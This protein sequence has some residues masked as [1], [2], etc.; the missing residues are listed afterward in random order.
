M[1]LDPLIIARCSVKSSLFYIMI[2][3]EDVGLPKRQQIDEP[4]VFTDETDVLT[5]TTAGSSADGGLVTADDM[6]TLQLDFHC[7]KVGTDINGRWVLDWDS[8]D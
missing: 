2:S 8:I 1:T 4:D 7:H 6:L 5:V 3:D